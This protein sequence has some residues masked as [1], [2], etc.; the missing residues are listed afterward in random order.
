MRLTYEQLNK[1]KQ[2]FNTEKIWSYSQISTY[3]EHDWLWYI[4]YILKKKPVADTNNVY[5]YFGNACHE[6]IQDYIENK[7][8]KEQMSDRFEDVVSDWELL[9]PHLTFPGKA[10]DSYI[11]NLTH[12]FKH[13]EYKFD[14]DKWEVSIEK[15]VLTTFKGSNNQNIVFVGY[16]DLLLID[17]ETGKHYIVD[18]KT[19]NKSSFSGKKLDESSRQLK[20]YAMGVSQVKNIPVED[21]VL[22]YDMQ[23]YVSVSFK[24]KNGKWSK[25]SLKERAKWITDYSNRIMSALDELDIDFVDATDMISESNYNQNLDNMPQEIQDKFRVE[26][27]FIDVELSENDLKNT[28]E[29]FINNV[30]EAESRAKADDLEAEFPEPDLSI[31]SNSFYYNVLEKAYLEFHQGYQDE[32]KAKQVMDKE[33][34]IDTEDEDALNDLFR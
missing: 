20:L 8:T 14:E 34:G 19:S 24:Q 7:I 16:I 32:K 29:W 6:I 2:Q 31:Q 17:K 23:K 5:S 25:P 13:T 1:L 33:L 3:S 21:I 10:G 11:E 15:P 28:S 12:Y 22:R 27:G 18:F 26:Q 30:E 9:Y 4:K